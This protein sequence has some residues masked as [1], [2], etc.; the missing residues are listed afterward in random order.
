M[1]LFDLEKL[2]T[3]AVVLFLLF[4]WTFF[5]TTVLLLIRSKM[6]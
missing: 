2:I 3:F 1:N 6:K 5:I 4:P